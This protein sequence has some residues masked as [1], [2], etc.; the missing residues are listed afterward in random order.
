MLESTSGSTVKNLEIEGGASTWALVRVQGTSG[1]Y[2]KNNTITGCHLHSAYGPNNG[3]FGVYGWYNDGLRVLG[4][5]I[6]DIA[7]DG[8]YL[9]FI[10]RLEVGYGD[11]YDVNTRY[12][13]NT[14]QSVSSGDGIQLNGLYDGFHIHHTTIDRSTT[15][16]KFALILNSSEA[17]SESASGVIEHCTFRGSPGAPVSLYIERGRGIVTRYNRFEDT[18]MGVRITGGLTSDNLIHHNLFYDSTDGVYVTTNAAGVPAGTRVYNN[19][20]YHVTGRH[21]GASRSP[22]EA[23]NNLHARAGDGGVALYSN[24]ATF[25]S[26]NHCYDTTATAGSLGVSGAS[27]VGSP[28]F[29]DGPGHDFRLQAGSPCLDRGVDV[30]LSVDFDGTPIPQ[31][32]APDIGAFE[33]R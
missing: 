27:V 13:V 31:R 33:R 23:R 14:D 22:V 4:T 18:P 21:I 24:N 25:V 6:H 5:E 11:I 3:G 1:S 9:H 28:L 10:T 29:V 16:N 15:G 19:V 32:G 12:R 17:G 8:M 26:S 7:L 2:T 20:F 30:G